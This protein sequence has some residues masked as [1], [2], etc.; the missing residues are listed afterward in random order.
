MRQPRLSRL[1]GLARVHILVRGLLLLAMAVPWLPLLPRC[2][3][4]LGLRV[5]PCLLGYLTG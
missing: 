1:L 3:K 4:G 2:L 5:L